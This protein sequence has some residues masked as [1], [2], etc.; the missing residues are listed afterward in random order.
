LIILY[1]IPA[2]IGIGI[3]KAYYI[4]T[5][6]PVVR[7]KTLEAEEIVAEEKRLLKALKKAE[8]NILKQKEKFSIY[9]KKEL[10]D[11][12]SAHSLF[13]SDPELKTKLLGIIN[14]E[15]V[16]AEYAVNKVFEEQIKFQQNERFIL[17]LKDIKNRILSELSPEIIVKIS[18]L[19]EDAII[20]AKE[21]YPSQT[22]ELFHHKV[23]GIITEMGGATSHTAIIARTLEIPAVVGLENLFSKI[24]HGDTV[25]VNGSEGTVIVNPSKKV[26]QNYKRKR[27]AFVQKE[28]TLLKCAIEPSK[29]IDNK[30]MQISANIELPEEIILVKKYCAEGIGLF[31]TEFLFHEH[32]KEFQKE[33]ERQFKI[34]KKVLQNISKDDSQYVIFRTFDI[35]GDKFFNLINY[36]YK[37]S[38]PFLGKRAARLY[39]DKEGKEVFKIQLRALLRASIY[40]NMRIMFPFITTIEE[41]R[42]IKKI[43]IECVDELKREK[44]PIKENIPLG[45]MIEIPSA[46]INA[47][48]LA[49]EVDFF[50]IGTNDLIQY[51]LAVD[52]NNENVNYLYDPFNLAVLRLIKEVIKVAKKKGKWIGICG[53]MASYPTGAIILTALGIDE[54]SVPPMY[55]P[56]IKEVIRNISFRNI[57]NIVNTHIFTSKDTKETKENIKKYILPILPK[58]IKEEFLS[59]WEKKL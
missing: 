15:K 6:C 3:G 10:E 54:L 13:F 33:E 37:E 24:N 5:K 30:Y 14:A 22:A 4:E 2:S 43:Y 29:T 46:A 27:K 17:D 52:R 11:I 7:K 40:G 56:I 53:E 31:R 41:I 32:L 16:N 18:D 28:K 8:T 21:L 35:G 23:A 25:I 9:G 47:D 50:S 57:R 51:T 19:P 38:N 26:L 48:I 42:E 1:G 20:I 58:I 36:P 49:E 12:Y 59:E 45:I 55:V 39:L 34:Y 44:Y